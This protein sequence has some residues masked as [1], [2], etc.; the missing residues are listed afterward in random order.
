M[1]GK[2]CAVANTHTRLQTQHRTKQSRTLSVRLFPFLL[3][4]RRRGWGGRLFCFYV[5]SVNIN[6]FSLFFLALHLRAAFFHAL[7]PKLSCRAVRARARATRLAAKQ[8]TGQR[9]HDSESNIMEK[10][11]LP[12]EGGE[13]RL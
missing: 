7:F 9:T 4:F 10:Q 11:R 12:K 6:Y 5:T 13:I 8:L 1:L 3:V 2:G